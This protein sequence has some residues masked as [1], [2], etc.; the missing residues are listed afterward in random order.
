MKDA[1][2]SRRQYLMQQE[3]ERDIKQSKHLSKELGSHIA[4]PE[5]S[6]YYHKILERLNYKYGWNPII[7][8]T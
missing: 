3:I 6:E 8:K 4:T 1:K 5:E 7:S 2:A